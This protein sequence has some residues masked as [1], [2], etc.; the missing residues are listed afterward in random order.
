MSMSNKLTK[1]LI[2]AVLQKRLYKKNTQNKQEQLRLHRFDDANVRFTPMI[3]SAECLRRS[4]AFV[5]LST[6]KSEDNRAFGTVPV[7]L[8]VLFCGVY[9]FIF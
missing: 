8:F 2:I 9:L 6:I 7:N 5:R 3:F 1:A 4:A